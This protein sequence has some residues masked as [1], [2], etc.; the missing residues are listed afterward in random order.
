MA[1]RPIEPNDPESPVEPPQPL[2]FDE[3]LVAS[4]RPALAQAF[5]DHGD[6]LRSVGIV[7]DYRG[8]LNDAAIQHGMWLGAQGTV[9]DAAAVIGSLGNSLKL[10]GVM[11]DRAFGLYQQ[12]SERLMVLSKEILEK[13]KYSDTLDRQI[14]EKTEGLP[15]ASDPQGP[16]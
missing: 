14:R 8:A 9:V 4:F 15:R 11:L 2:M 7:F 6:V 1:E 16:C 13:E 3:A 10:T 12:L 5:L